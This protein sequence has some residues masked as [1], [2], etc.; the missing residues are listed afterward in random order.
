M[1]L[2]RSVADVLADHVTLEVECID[3]MY[4]NVYVPKLQFTD[5]VVCFLRKHR[6]HRFASSVLLEPIS[7]AFVAGIHR[8]ARDQGVPLVDFAK[9]QRKDDLAREFLA[10]FE[11][12]EGVLFV[13]R[14]QERA[15]VFRTEKRR[16]P[17][18]GATYPWIVKTTAMVNHFYLYAVDADF[19]PFFIKFCGY[20]PYNARLCLNGNEWAKRQAA[21]S[22]IGFEALDNGFAACDD[23]RLQRI[24]D[25]F[26]PKDIDRLLRPL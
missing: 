18:T 22:G 21:K 12:T 23:R 11:G 13:G 7:R 3:R 8:F 5:G 15:T 19:G 4:L 16:N 10:G 25:R 9:G 26:G 1:T 2:P 20:F 17:H 14:A 6:G 24:C